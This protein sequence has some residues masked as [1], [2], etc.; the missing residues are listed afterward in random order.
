[1]KSAYIISAYKLPQFLYRLVDA[2]QGAP[3]AI[4][5]D[6]KSD[7]Y[8]EVTAH[9]AAYPNVTFLPRHNCYWGLFG[10]VRAS[11][12]GM[13]WF[14]ATEYDYALL[15]TAQCYPLKTIARIETEL[16][17][18][19]G[20]SVMQ[21]EPFPRQEWMQYEN[22]GY[23]RVEEFYFQLGRLRRIK[24][25]RRKL[26]YK[27]HPY[28]G[29]GYWCL[30]RSAVSYVLDYVR[31][32]KRLTRFFATTLIP[33]ELFFH[34]ILGNSPLREQLINNPLHYMTWADGSSH[35][36]V[37]GVDAVATMCESGKWFA[38]K[39]DD[40]AVLDAIDARVG[41]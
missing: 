2:L 4:H 6:L 26:P 35:P 27:L 14:M 18:L 20:R 25:W 9:F 17:D 12:E 11:L 3:V 5:I 7:I 38:R 34:T 32:H 16:D 23:R 10:H 29:S 22:G 31:S 28:G 41:R 1:M 39:F 21:C 8:P 24:L 13:K 15:L 36:A 30:S 33:D 37:L 19:Q 40:I